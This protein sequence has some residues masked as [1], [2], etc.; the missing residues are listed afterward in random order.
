M[1]GGTACPAPGS[2]ATFGYCNGKLTKT[3]SMVDTEITP[4]PTAHTMEFYYKGLNGRMS[5]ERNIFAGWP[6]SPVAPIVTTYNKF[7]LAS[8]TD[9][10]EGPA[11]KLGLFAITYTYAN[12]YP[13]EAWDPAQT[14]QAQAKFTYN[15]A[16]GLQEILTFGNGKTTFAPDNRNRPLDITIGKW[17][18]PTS[19][20]I[21]TDLHAGPYSYDAA[22]NIYQIGPEAGPKNSYGYDAANR[23]IKAVDNYDTLRTQTYTYDDF[24]N[25]TQ[26]VHIDING[27]L[28]DL[29]TVLDQSTGVNRNQILTHQVEST[30]YLF[31]Y[32]ARGNVVGGD[33]QTYKLDTRNRMLSYLTKSAG[34][35]TEGARYTYDGGGNRVRKEDQA[36]D[37]WTFYARDSQGRLMSEFRRP[38]QGAATPEWSKHYVYLGGRLVSLRENLIPTPPGGLKATTSVNGNNG[39]VNLTWMPNATGE[40]TVVSGYNVYRTKQS[41]ISWEKRTQTPTPNA[42]YSDS[43]TVGTWY[44]Y[45]I[46]AVS[47]SGES[48]PSDQ[49]LTMAKAFYPSV[50][51]PTGLAAA[52]WDRRVELT[53]TASADPT[54][55]YHVYRSIGGGSQVRLTQA[56]VRQASHSDQLL[57]NGLDHTYAITAINTVNVESPQTATVSATPADYTPPSVPQDF[58]AVADCNGT[59]N[60]SLYWSPPEFVDQITSYTL[61]RTPQ[62]PGGP[63]SLGGGINMYTDTTPVSGTTYSYTLNA[64]DA[65]NNVSDLS[66]SAVVRTRDAAGTVVVPKTPFARSADGK[67]TIRLYQS[68][69]GITGVRVYRKP[70]IATDCSAFQLVGEVSAT[71]TPNPFPFTTYDMIDGTAPN[72]VAYDY[73][74]TNVNGT[75]ESGFSTP[76]LGIPVGRPMNYSECV[77]ELPAMVDGAIDCSGA[78]WDTFRRLVVTFSQPKSRPYQPLSDHSDGSPGYLVGYRIYS[79][80]ITST[81]TDTD[82]STV[83]PLAYDWAKSYCRH[84]P[85]VV[86]MNESVPAEACRTGSF[87]SVTGQACPCPAGTGICVT[88]SCNVINSGH[89]DIFNQPNLEGVC[90]FT[91]MKCL[92]DS[93]CPGTEECL[94][95]PMDPTLLIAKD[96]RLNS[97]Y[98]LITENDCL[99]AKAV[100]RVF[101]N[102]NWLTVESEFS[103]NYNVNQKVDQ[104]GRCVL[105]HSRDACEYL[106]PEDSSFACPK[107]SAL[108]QT[109]AAPT[110]TS[111]SPGTIVVNWATT[112]PLAGICELALPATCQRNGPFCD[113]GQYCSEADGARTVPPMG[114][115]CR[116]NNNPPTQCNVTGDCPTSPAQTCVINTDSQIAGWRLYAIETNAGTDP[117]SSNP[118]TAAYHY[119]P[120]SPATEFA[121]DSG[122]HSHTFTN[123]SD[124]L[125]LNHPTAFRFRVAA[126]DG[127]GRVSALSPPSIGITPMPSAATIKPPAGLK[128]VVWTLN[129]ANKDYWAYANPNENP[130]AL[131]GIKIS[132]RDDHPNGLGQDVHLLGYRLYRSPVSTGPYCVLLQSGPNNPPGVPLCVNNLTG[133]P[134]DPNAQ[135]DLYTTAG[136]RVYVDKTVKQNTRYFYVVTVVM[137][138]GESPYSNET[139]GISLPHAT[140]PLSPP[141]HFQAVSPNGFNEWT[142]VYLKWCPNPDVEAITGYNVYRS[143]QPGGPYTR[144]NTGVC[145]VGGQ[146]CLVD[147]TCTPG[148]CSPRPIPPACLDGRTRCVMNGDGSV[149][150]TTGSCSDRVT[151]TCQVV[152][153]TV[154]QPS[155][156]TPQDQVTNFVYYYVVTAMRGTTE[157]GYSMENSGWP[158]YIGSPQGNAIRYDPDNFPP[159]PCGDMDAAFEHE[160]S[161]LAVADDEG[162]RLQ[163]APYRILGA[164]V[165]LPTPSAVPR[166]IYYH[167]DH[168]GTPRVILDN[169][170]NF[171][172]KHHYMPFGQE[173]PGVSQEST[174][175]R[176]FTAHERDPESGLDYMLARYYSSSLGRFMAV[177]PIGDVS[178]EDPQSWN[179]FA[180]TR[181]NPIAYADP[182]GTGACLGSVSCFGYGAGS[183]NS[184]GADAGYDGAKT[185]ETMVT[186]AACPGSMNTTASPWNLDARGFWMGVG[187][188]FRGGLINNTLQMHWFDIEN[189]GALFGVDPNL[190]R[191]VIYEEQ[192]HQMPFESLA[193]SAGVG[194]TIGMGQITVGLHGYSRQQLLDPSTNI[195]VI[196]IHL[197]ALMGQPLINPSDPIGSI[198]TSYNCESCGSVSSYGRRVSYYYDQFKSGGL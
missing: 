129:D 194:D 65:N 131:D 99:A 85:E 108:P 167:L 56:P 51:T 4:Q 180:Y 10:P 32:D 121:L 126:V 106:Y 20:F 60:V 95:G 58:Q 94:F 135:S 88:N 115:K 59:S 71:Q 76:A 181:N 198:A 97:G 39:T 42:F 153:S 179:S 172:S 130:R 28:T 22:G 104:A 48:Y 91:S 34:Q 139:A 152:D 14:S 26:K 84:E 70:N 12:G 92:L 137:D 164:G 17:D 87:C 159:T 160:P 186:D 62:F 50:P 123:L 175:K 38:R 196:G 57:I 33:T 188:Y 197:S 6:A 149:T 154:N 114:G 67:V 192:A 61:S 111:P 52:A 40:G 144:L 182:S 35:S 146:S 134:G 27:S 41:P 132:W 29:F 105:G 147:S 168:L 73:V 69:P 173:M 127:Q 156:Q 163:A 103:E 195:M 155:T 148:V 190:I 193:E 25:M 143:Q 46:T 122:T 83:T 77:E 79:Y 66:L 107:S 119:L 120:S 31:A 174:N 13:I 18:V 21:R 185:G 141:S 177:D 138:T 109:P 142:G 75:Q 64:R 68:D 158:N 43:V 23:L 11:G 184:V 112:S 54:I 145:S 113:S 1:A 178:P 157:S 7:G 5:D 72:N 45:V 136:A 16:G 19:S 150:Q 189:T 128:S 49:L 89:H 166:F 110:A 44:L 102:G 118:S 117:A 101:A 3:V 30:P 125:S 81:I 169:A 140:Q 2:D 98:R 191:A 82:D 80:R 124:H 86:C 63:I 93:D 24:G 151:G 133:Q 96:G 170:G 161:Q 9:Y 176:Q 171:I 53:W 15:A 183:T 36:R 90:Q 74:A 100:Y 187:E 78:S 47:A 165:T 8:R 55:S 37:L 162:D 116:L